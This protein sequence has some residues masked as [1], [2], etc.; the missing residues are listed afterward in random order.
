MNL[1]DV[2]VEGEYSGY[3]LK[4]VVH[5]NPAYVYINLDMDKMDT[6]TRDYVMERFDAWCKYPTVKVG[7]NNASFTY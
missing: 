6:E 4:E 2:L 5:W 7:Y 1:K 3:P